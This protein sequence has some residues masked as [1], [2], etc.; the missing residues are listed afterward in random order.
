VN[1]VAEQDP[2]DPDYL[3]RVEIETKHVGQPGQVYMIGRSVKGR[4]LWR[5]KWWGTE[6]C[7][8]AMHLLSEAMNARDREIE[9]GT[10][11]SLDQQ[12]QLKVRA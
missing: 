7:D 1:A 5:V 10:V 3:Y 4:Q 9:V 11:M 2:H 12:G 6:A 8:F